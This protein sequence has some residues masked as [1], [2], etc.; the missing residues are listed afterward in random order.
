MTK[1]KIQHQ[2]PTKLKPYARNARTHSAKQIA[3]IAASIRKFGFNNPPFITVL[4]DKKNTIIA[5]P[6]ARVGIG[7]ASMVLADRPA[8]SGSTVYKGDKQK[9]A[10]SRRRNPLA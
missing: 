4:I 1:L 3:Q 9:N 2:P 10:V 8:L 5:G 7:S 6:G